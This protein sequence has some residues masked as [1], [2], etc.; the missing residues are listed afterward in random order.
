MGTYLSTHK[1]NLR[2][3]AAEFDFLGF[4]FDCPNLL[5]SVKASRKEKIQ[6]QIQNM[7]TSI[8]VCFDELEKLRG[9]LISIS[10]I[11][12]FARLYI[13]EMNRLL[14]VAEKYLQVILNSIFPIFTFY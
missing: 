12:P 7:F 5:V 1:A 3:P 9:R 2:E 8:I 4:H 14:Q 11:C 10:L 6:A 13:R